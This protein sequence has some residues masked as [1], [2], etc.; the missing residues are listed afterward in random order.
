MIE[1]LIELIIEVAGDILFQVSAEV[2]AELGF[3]CLE[4]VVRPRREANP[5]YACLGLLFLG[6]LLGVAGGLVFPHRLLHVSRLPGLSLVLTP[7]G[8]GIV[9]HLFGTWRRSRGRNPTF[10]ASFWGGVAFAFGLALA[11]FLML[12]R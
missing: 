9:M 6:G 1:C 12:G 2:L 8:S 10:L 11:R 3:E 4:N 5:I 7:V